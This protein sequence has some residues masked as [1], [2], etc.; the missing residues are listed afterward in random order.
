MRVRSLIEHYTLDDYRHWEGDWELIH[1]VPLAM[2]PSPVIQHQRIA[3]RIASQL[4]EAL[5]HCPHCEA[6]FEID[7]EF[8]QDTVVRPDV[9]VICYKPEGE[10]LNR[11]P[12]LVF[13]VIS[14][15][16]ARRDEQTKFQLYRDEGVTWYVL[17]Y[18]ASDKAKVYRLI[19]G[20]YRKVDDFHDDAYD[21]DLSRCT[22]AFDFG[23]LWHRRR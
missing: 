19:D 14:S 11:A 5:D 8:S 15:A 23:R 13:E 2:S 3:M 17:V 4:D 12:E 21:F 9:I 22:L 1:G 16:T 18:P 6:L 7:V 20:D 10:R